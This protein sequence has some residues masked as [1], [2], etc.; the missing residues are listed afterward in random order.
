M[1]SSDRY[2]PVRRTRRR[3]DEPL[4]VLHSPLGLWPQLPSS[5][6]YLNTVTGH[7]AVFFCP[8]G[9]PLAVR[10]GSLT[11][12]T[13][14][15]L[16][17]AWMLLLDDEID[18]QPATLPAFSLE[19][20]LAV[21]RGLLGSQVTPWTKRWAGGALGAPRLHDHGAQELVCAVLLVGVSPTAVHVERALQQALW[22]TPALAKYRAT[23]EQDVPENYEQV[24]SEY[25]VLELAAR[26]A[27]TPKTRRD[28]SAVAGA[29]W[30]RVLLPLEAGMTASRVIEPP[31]ASV[32][33]QEALADAARGDV[34]T[35]G[36]GAT[37]TSDRGEARASER[38]ASAERGT[39]LDDTTTV[40]AHRSARQRP[41][42]LAGP[43]MASVIHDLERCLRHGRLEESLAGFPGGGGVLRTKIV[44]LQ[45]RL[46]A[47]ARARTT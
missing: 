1:A 15:A 4:A 29:Y 8:P 36:E 47:A 38:G 43:D 21:T 31:E 5:A 44:A 2:P 14:A 18:C 46:D 28:T 45:E 41:R 26:R 27:R 16:T 7:A 40:E 22:A 17:K 24:R 33:L 20:T 30:Q 6:T 3:A 32:S 34:D 39:A 10:T 9:S 11:V 23:W 12:Y 13:P 42:P 37:D 35:F 25:E 19:Q